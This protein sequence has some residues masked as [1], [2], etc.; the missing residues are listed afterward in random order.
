MRRSEWFTVAVAIMS[1]EDATTDREEVF[2][3]LRE[4]VMDVHY[5]GPGGQSWA[6]YSFG[7]DSDRSS[8]N[9]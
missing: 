4:Q 5:V 9:G 7:I 2:A 8:D 1:D 6:V 3:M